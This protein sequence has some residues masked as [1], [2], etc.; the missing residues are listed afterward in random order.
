MLCRSVPGRV[1]LPGCRASADCAGAGALPADAALHPP[2]EPLPVL[3]EE[4]H[5]HP[6]ELYGVGIGVN[7]PGVAVEQVEVDRGRAGEPSQ[8]VQPEA[9]REVAAEAHAVGVDE[10]EGVS[11]LSLPAVEDVADVEVE[12]FDAGIVQAEQKGGQCI[13]NLPPPGHRTVEFHDRQQGVEL[14]AERDEVALG[15]H[16]AAADFEEGNLLGRIDAPLAQLRRVEVGPFGLAPAQ[17]PV[18]KTVEQRQMAVALDHDADAL[19]LEELERVAPVV[20]RLAVCVEVSGFG[21]VPDKGFE[22]MVARIDA[23]FH[24]FAG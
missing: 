6:L 24:D 1:G 13:E 14:G 5:E 16:S 10:L 22:C 20:Q 8:V 11:R 18:E 19:H 7:Q 4:P 9:G 12:V 2:L 15:E 21:K 17:N 23:E 3:E